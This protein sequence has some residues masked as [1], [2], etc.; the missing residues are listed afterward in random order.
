MTRDEKIEALQNAQELMN[1]ALRSIERIARL[2]PNKE[3][4]VY[5]HLDSLINTPSNRYD[6]SL[7]TWIEEL[8]EEAEEDEEDEEE[9]CPEEGSDEERELLG[10]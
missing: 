8:Y 9:E 5:E 10:Q 4:Y 7:L 6:Q 2:D 3:A 1:E